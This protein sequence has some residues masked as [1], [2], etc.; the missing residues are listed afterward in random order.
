MNTHLLAS[1][2]LHALATQWKRGKYLMLPL[3]YQKTNTCKRTVTDSCLTQWH[4]Y[5]NLHLCLYSA[6]TRYIQGAGRHGRNREFTVM[7]YKVDR[8]SRKRA[9]DI[10]LP[11]L[12]PSH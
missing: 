1:T 6:E 3:A 10:W 7:Y 12:C 2:Y 11:G 5:G 9:Q 4:V 8:E